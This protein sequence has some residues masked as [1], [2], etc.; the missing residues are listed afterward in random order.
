MASGEWG[1]VNLSVQV[2]KKR[3]I[4]TQRRQGC[5][6]RKGFGE[7]I[8]GEVTRM[9]WSALSETEG[10]SLD[11]VVGRLTGDERVLGIVLL[12][13]TGDGSVTADSDYDLLLIL[14]EMPVPLHV[15]FT[16]IEGRLADVIFGEERFIDRI[17]AEDDPAPDSAAMGALM[18]WRSGRLSL[19]GV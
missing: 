6:E 15:V 1:V 19:S 8:T 11:E 4:S 5:K 9:S 2:F 7:G 13:S 14:A 10:L 3:I 18:N 12:G 17:L 16:T